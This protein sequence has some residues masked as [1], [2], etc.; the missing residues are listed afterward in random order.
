MNES[1]YTLEVYEPGSSKSVWMSFTTSRPFMSI[2]VGDIINP[3]T[4]PGSQSPMKVLA[5]TKVE[6]I[7]RE[8][9]GKVTHKACI[10]TTE[11][12]EE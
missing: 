4:W 12:S 2:Q 8:S 11:V 7:I 5:V 6:H 10:Y 9:H 3:G 1:E